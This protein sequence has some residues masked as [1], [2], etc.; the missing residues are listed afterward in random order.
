MLPRNI[1][2][3][4]LTLTA[5]TFA[6][7]PITLGSGVPL[8]PGPAKENSGIVRSRN[9]PDLFWMINDSGDEPRVYPVRRDGEVVTSTRSP[10]TPGVLVG[11]AINVD[12]E[13]IAITAAGEL[14]VP[15][16]GNNDNDRRDLVLYVIDEPAPTAARATFRRKIFV[17]YPDQTSHPA[18]KDNFNFDCEGVF[19][20]AGKIHLLTKHRSDSLT[21]LYRLDTA[22]PEVVNELTFIEEFDPQGQVTAADAL[23]DGSRLLVATYTDL[24]LFDAPDPAH[25]LAGPHVRIPLRN[26]KQIEAACFLSPTTALLADEVTAH[27]YEIPLPPLN[28]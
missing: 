4:A 8:R 7:E 9:W 25:P 6:A 10:S 18:P 16:V 5:P 26:A 17:R 22:E 13:D 1:L 23:P 27:L 28:R 24:W 3:L 14:I 11:G 21:R 19:T 15:D 2:L 20:L 12:W